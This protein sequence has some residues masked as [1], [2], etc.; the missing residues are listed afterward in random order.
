MCA[1]CGDRARIE[2]IPHDRAAVESLKMQS[3]DGLTLAER[4]I[5]QLE[6]AVEY[7]VHFIGVL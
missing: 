7:P 2:W 3:K 4:T 6:A 5:T 1:G